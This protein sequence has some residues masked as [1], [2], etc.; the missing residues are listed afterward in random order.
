MRQ[1]EV[2]YFRDLLIKMKNGL[3]NTIN[4]MKE[5]DI[6]EQD[7]YSPSELSNYDNHPADIGSELFQT[8][9][10]NALIVHEEAFL[11]DVENALKKIDAGEFGKCELCGNNIETD[12]LRVIP[13]TALCKQCADK[14]AA[15]SDE[16]RHTRPVEEQV[17]VSPFGR[18]YLNQQD[19]DEY[20][21]L[22]YINDLMK[23][24]SSDTPQDM[25]GYKDYKEF[26][27]N[28]VD[29]QGIV[30]K[31]DNISNQKHKK[32]LP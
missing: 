17:M 6:G 24:G 29:R 7:K 10:G 21:G 12:R 19:D 28:E 14:R 22:D 2:E 9:H 5:H 16:L 30:D 8:E 25:G 1:D 23:Y 13:Y 11:N 4:M 31:M 20:E 18:K 26:Y 15:E 3:H 27:T 32:Q